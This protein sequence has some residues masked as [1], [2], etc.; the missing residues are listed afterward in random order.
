VISLIDVETLAAWVATLVAEAMAI[1]R[2]TGEAVVTCGHEVSHGTGIT[3]SGEIPTKVGV[4]VFLGTAGPEVET[5][6]S[7]SQ[8][9]RIGYPGRS[10]YALAEAPTEAGS[11]GGSKL[12]LKGTGWKADGTSWSMDG[13]KVVSGT[14]CTVISGTRLTPSKP[15]AR[16]LA[17]LVHLGLA[18]YGEATPVVVSGAR[19]TPNMA[20]AGVPASS[21]CSGPTA[22]EVPPPA[23]PR[24]SRLLLL[25]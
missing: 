8:D 24:L 12:N 11:L 21:P 19:T 16:V 25:R 15:F 14:D 20:P 18:H 17:S 3:E 10:G 9:D 1:V 6:V 23:W 7:R 4:V 13:D 5:A 22:D 2:A